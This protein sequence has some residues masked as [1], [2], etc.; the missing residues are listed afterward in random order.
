MYRP[1]RAALVLS[2]CLASPLVLVGRSLVRAEERPPLGDYIV[3]SW[4]D[5]GMHCM[6]ETHEKFSILPPYNNVYAQLIQRGDANS[7]PQVINEGVTLEYSIPGN[8]YSVGKTDFWTYA[9]DLFGVNLPDDVGL[10]GKGLTG[11]LD[12][13]SG[14]FV[15]EGVPLT[16]FPDAT[17]TTEDPYQQAE[18]IA[19][20]GVGTILAESAPVLP[21]S[22]ELRCVSSGCHS[23]EQAILNAHEREQG[24][25]PNNTPILCAGCHASPALGTQ[26]NQEAG[27]FS[28]RIHDRH[29][30]LDET[31][32]GIDGCYK[33]HPGVH[34]RCLRGTMGTDFGLEC[35]DCH[36]NMRNMAR[37]I[38]QGRIPWLNEPR[39]ETCHTS[40]FGEE[41]GQLY[42]LS[43]G[44]GGV[45]CSGCH[46][47]PHAIYPSGLDRDNANVVSLQGSAGTL[48]DCTVCHGVTP[49][50]AGPHGIMSTSGVPEG[51]NGLE[52]EILN[53]VQQITI[54]PN[55]VVD[56]ARFSIP[57]G[58]GDE[59]KLLVFDASGRTLALFKPHRAGDGSLFVEWQGEGRK[60][61][62]VGP[63]VYFVRW[64]NG[65]RKAGGKVVVR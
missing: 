60:G 4:N 23:S 27:Y 6:N 34:A 40:Q 49:N 51:G 8:T 10:T 52:S 57:A 11:E 3:L 46:N 48:S 61:E 37:T 21:V 41:P 30:F 53:G 5:L 55:P 12:P 62:Q 33:C 54:A 64:Q 13:V 59:G 2:L 28:R 19:R 31:L 24:F 56:S 42:R 15:A 9:F 63:G 43:T 25:N 45:M 20:D 18:I 26:G 16:P 22:T 38:E 1:N 29:D 32:P 65:V 47:S 39:C 36:G 17:P 35:Q 44:H 50:G 7:L 58:E 14:R